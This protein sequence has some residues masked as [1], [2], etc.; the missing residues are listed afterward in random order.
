MKLQ[1]VDRC[2][3]SLLLFSLLLLAFFSG[4]YSLVAQELQRKQVTATQYC[5]FLNYAAASDFDHL[6][7]ESM[8][9]DPEAASILRTGTPGSYHYEVIAGRENFPI[10]YV[11]A[12]AQSA[13][14]NEQG[15][16]D[17][18]ENFN[19]D[20]FLKSNR[21]DFYAAVSAPP[22]QVSLLPVAVAAAAVASYSPY[23]AAVFATFG[24]VF[25]SMCSG[26]AENEPP[27]E[28][29]NTDP[30]RDLHQS[31]LGEHGSS[32]SA[33]DILGEHGASSSAYNTHLPI[34]VPSVDGSRMLQEPSMHESVENPSEQ[35]SEKKL[36]HSDKVQPGELVESDLKNLNFEEFAKK[37]EE[38]RATG[39]E[40]SKAPLQSI[41]EEC[42]TPTPSRNPSFIGSPTRTLQDF[43]PDYKEG[44]VSNLDALGEASGKLPV[45][46]LGELKGTYDDDPD[47]MTKGRESTEEGSENSGSAIEK[48]KKNR[49]NSV[50]GSVRS[51]RSG[52][53]NRSKISNKILNDPFSGIGK[54]IKKKGTSSKKTNEDKGKKEE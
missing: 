20:A 32:S 36:V 7:D 48:D 49:R 2:H 1:K 10:T 19:E 28:I 11:S 16:S 42:Q 23:I 30:S 5:D 26:S 52:S 15:F 43:I 46:H 24:G 35:T 25:F 41:E 31:L 51:G 27:A 40:L 44:E 6:Y 4:S 14:C 3:S 18:D 39:E 37:Q 21:I 54:K 45:V 29:V 17:D 34:N 13:F 12:Y 47:I 22:N 50:T 53:T 8:S 38:K 33:Y 9:T